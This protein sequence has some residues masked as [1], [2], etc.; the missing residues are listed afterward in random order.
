[1]SPG[2]PLVAYFEVYHLALGTEGQARFEYETAVRSAARDR[3][4]WIQ[5]WLSPRREGESL[6]VTRQ[7]VVL[8]TVRRQYLSVPVQDLPEGRYRLDVTVRD[9]LTGEE[10]RRSAEFTKQAAA[11]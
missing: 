5:R 11:R 9:V 3:R 8:G 2:E 6:G 4:M 1:M 7:D 10:R